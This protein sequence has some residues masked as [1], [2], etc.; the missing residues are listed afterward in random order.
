ML[1]ISTFK[2]HGF[3][4]VP[5]ESPPLQ[6]TT[7]MVQKMYYYGIYNMVQTFMFFAPLSAD[8]FSSSRVAADPRHTHMRDLSNLQPQILSLDGHTCTALF[9]PRQWAD[10]QEQVQLD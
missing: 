2:N 4:M 3:T 1:W 6:K 7:A 10:L 8:I 9:W 5:Q